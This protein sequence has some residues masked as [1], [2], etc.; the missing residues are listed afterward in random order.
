MSFKGTGG[1]RRLGIA[2]GVSVVVHIVA[3]CVFVMIGSG[4]G[5]ETASSEPP[6]LPPPPDELSSVDQPAA[7]ADMGAVTTRAEEDRL[8]AEEAAKPAKTKPAATKKPDQPKKADSP[9]KTE[10]AKPKPAET[11]PAATKK[12]DQPK[13]SETA[14]TELAE[15]ESDEPRVEWKTYEVRPGDSLTKIARKCGCTVQELAKANGL[16]ADANLNLGQKIKIKAE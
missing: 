5:K 4:G 11:K 1:P 9:K 15:T 8:A 6:P 2:I 16:R 12:P 7:V 3:F 13:K 14:K 10:S